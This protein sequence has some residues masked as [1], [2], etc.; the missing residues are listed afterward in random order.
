MI[1]KL[2]SKL[3]VQSIIHAFLFYLGIIKTCK[4]K[5][6]NKNKNE[7]KQCIKANK[8]RNKQANRQTNK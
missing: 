2:F 1:S 8:Q 7:N 4:T 6:K 5:T 3:Y